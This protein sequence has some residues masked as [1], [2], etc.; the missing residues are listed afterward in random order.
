MAAAGSWCTTSIP[1][2][3]D[4]QREK[5]GKGVDLRYSLGLTLTED[6]TVVDVLGR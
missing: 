5:Q 4:A 1:N 6:G 3:V 2:K